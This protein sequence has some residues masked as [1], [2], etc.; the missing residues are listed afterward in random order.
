MQV[1]DDIPAG[2]NVVCP[3]CGTTRSIDRGAFMQSAKIPAKWKKEVL[4]S[5]G[6]EDKDI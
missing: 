6:I 5:I 2:S 1:G 4:K 3:N